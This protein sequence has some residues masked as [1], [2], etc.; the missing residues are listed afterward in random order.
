MDNFELPVFLDNNTEFNTLCSSYYNNE[1][2]TPFIS[3]YSEFFNDVFPNINSPYEPFDTDFTT[4][5][6]PRSELPEPSKSPSISPDELSLE[7]PELTSDIPLEAPLNDNNYQYN[8]AVGDFFD[9]WLLV[10][11]FMHQYCLERGFGYQ[12]YR[13]DK[14]SEDPTI[15]RHKSF[16]CSSSGNYE[17]RK[18]INQNLHRLRG[19]I[20]TNC[21]WH[22]NFTFPKTAY[23]VKCT[24]L[25]DMHNHEINPAQVS[26]IIARYRRLNNEMVQDLQF[27]L[28]CKVAPIIQ[29]EILKKKYPEHVFHKQDVYNAIYKLRQ[30]N[31][32]ERPDSALF[33]DVLLAKI[34]QDPR[35]KIF[36]RHSGNEFRL[37]GIFWMSPSQQELYQRFSDVVLSDN[38]CKTNKYNMYL[39]VL[40]V[41]DNYGRFRNI[42][43]ALVE[44]ELSL[45]Y[46]WILQ[47]LLKATDNTIP[48]SIWT[49]SEPGL[50]NAIS[51]VFP[52]TL[53]FYCLFHIWQNVIK[54]L[55]GKLGSKFQLFSKAFYSCRNVLSVD[56]FEQRWKYMLKEFPECERYMTR[57]LYAN[58]ISWAKAY[59]PFQFNAGIQSTQG[60]ESF[61]AIIKRAV[62]SASTLC[63]IENAIDKRHQEEIQYCQL[64]DIKAKYTT[65]G[66][67]HL[68]SQFFSSIDPV[69]AKFLPPLILSLQ[70][71]Q[72]SQ[73]FTYEGQITSSYLSEVCVYYLIRRLKSNVML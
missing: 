20:K 3:P 28:D 38:T 41:K 47:C 43:N 31:M 52:T 2:T 11:T 61:N 46:V 55:K 33:L 71:F 29:L 22:V 15:I 17:S 59:T 67:P 69:I 39:S 18:K 68:S 7:S 51:Q 5:F 26:H 44:D 24:T 48:K 10:D 35:W 57:A 1:I 21:E 6:K 14:D 30:N 34:T 4:S 16:R 40:M 32:D 25:K 36:I 65:I 8:L 13:N 54:N 53:H 62:N 9:D 58:R 66:L 12:I 70:R 64:T 56:L 60:V 63:D 27:F 45:T 72:I 73:A 50:I 37:S 42:A 49:D 19:T 23:Q